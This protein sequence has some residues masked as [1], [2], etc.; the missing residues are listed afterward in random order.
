[1]SDAEVRELRR[2]AREG[3]GAALERLQAS[4]LRTHHLE[5][6]EDPE[7]GAPRV[8]GVGM[9]GAVS[10]KHVMFDRE[11]LSRSQVYVELFRDMRAY[12]CPSVEDVKQPSDSNF[13]CWHPGNHAYDFH[14]YRVLM[15]VDAGTDQRDAEVVWNRGKLVLSMIYNRTH[16]WPC[17]MVMPPP[18]SLPTS[19]L[20]LARIVL[21]LDCGADVTV[22]RRPVT[23]HRRTEGGF[24]LECPTA[25]NGRVAFMVV[26]QGIGV[27]A[28]NA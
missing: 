18:R 3:D 13:G 23:L 19:E 4:W 5:E 26:M 22:S 11:V 24:R 14:L 2:R 16:E 28:V 1:L 15:L 12:A 21:P 17:R 8:A 25:R 27:Q 10:R 20:E 9:I 6:A 7:D